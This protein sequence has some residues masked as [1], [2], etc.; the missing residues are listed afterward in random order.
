MHTYIHTYVRTY[1]HAC[2]SVYRASGWRSAYST[3]LRPSK[4]M[5]LLPFR[6]PLLPRYSLYVCVPVRVYVYVCV[7]VCVYVYSACVRENGTG[8]GVAQFRKW[9]D[10]SSETAT[11][12]V[13]SVAAI[14]AFFLILFVSSK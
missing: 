4:R 1:I 2:T 10:S 6:M 3:S 11:T 7:C 5:P 13:A 12:C 8:D 9:T 14:L